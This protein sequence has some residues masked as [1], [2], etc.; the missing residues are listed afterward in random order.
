MMRVLALRLTARSLVL[1]ACETGLVVA[2]AAAAAYVRLGDGAWDL[3]ITDQGWTKALLISAV[4]QAC[5]YYADLYDL[6]L[7]SDRREL[8]TRILHALASASLVL[9]ALYFW[10]PSLIIGRGVFVIAAVFVMTLVVG[11][12]IAFEWASRRIRPSE[13]LLLVCN[14]AAPILLAREI[15]ER[16]AEL[17]VEIVGFIDPD[18][19]RV[20]SPIINPGVVGTIDDI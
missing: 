9:A 2:A 13:R 19:M 10:F 4:A 18:P 14:N 12:R 8:F 15:F 1:I 6:R 3:L 16:R 5:M 7:L 11:W 17:G 20:G